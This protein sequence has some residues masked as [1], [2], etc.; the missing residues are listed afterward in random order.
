[1]SAYFKSE[2]NYAHPDS[3]HMSK[4]S[5]FHIHEFCI[6]DGYHMLSKDVD[7]GWKLS[8]FYFILFLFFQLPG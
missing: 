6:C 5:E 4:S 8:F 1:M 2:R 7:H 3:T